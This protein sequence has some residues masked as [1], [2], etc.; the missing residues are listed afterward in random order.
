MIFRLNRYSSEGSQRFFITPG[1]WFRGRRVTAVD[2]DWTSGVVTVEV[3][4]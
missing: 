3:P 4:A 1:A 2:I